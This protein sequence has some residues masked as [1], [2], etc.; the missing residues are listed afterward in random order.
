M[1]TKITIEYHLP[2]ISY[3]PRNIMN[4]GH[5]HIPSLLP[6]LIPLIPLL[7]LR[8]LLPPK[9]SSLHTCVL[10]WSLI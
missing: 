4:F 2:L 8:A 3:L 9:S 7:L 6:S 1:K 10:F 5:F